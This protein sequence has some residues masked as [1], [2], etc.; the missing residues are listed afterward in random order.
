MIEKTRGS[1]RRDPR[2]IQARRGPDGLRRLCLLEGVVGFVRQL[3]AEVGAGVAS[4][5]SRQAESV[6]GRVVPLNRGGINA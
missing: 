6:T 1:H 5:P 4:L 3:A 2:R